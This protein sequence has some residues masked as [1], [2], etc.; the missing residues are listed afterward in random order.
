MDVRFVHHSCAVVFIHFAL[1]GEDQ[2]EPSVDRSRRK[3]RPSW[4]IGQRPARVTLYT[5]SPGYRIP[6]DWF[7]IFLKRI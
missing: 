3:V 5:L 7:P 2:L 6:H 4:P 1:S